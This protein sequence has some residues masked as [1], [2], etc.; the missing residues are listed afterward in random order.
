MLKF[1][2]GFIN[3]NLLYQDLFDSLGRKDAYTL[4]GIDKNISSKEIKEK[5][6]NKKFK[7]KSVESAYK[8]LSNKKLRDR[9]DGKIVDISS[10]YVDGIDKPVSVKTVV[11]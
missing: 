2:N 11:F 1:F 3:E 8:I 4:L 9:Y 6:L 5:F 10:L 7:N